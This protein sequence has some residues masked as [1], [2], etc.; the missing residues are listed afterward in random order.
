MARPI[1]VLPLVGSTT[2]APRLSAPRRSA[3]SIMATAIRSLTLPPGFSDSILARTAAPSLL[4]SRLSFTSGV[5]PTTSSTEAAIFGRPV[6]AGLRWV[7]AP[8]PIGNA[9]SP[10]KK[11]S[12]VIHGFRESPTL[13]SL[14]PEILE[15]GAVDDRIYGLRNRAPQRHEIARGISRHATAGPSGAAHSRRPLHGAQDSAHRDLRGRLGQPIT[16][17]RAAPRVEKPHSLEAQEHLF[18]V[19]LGNALALR[20]VLDGLEGVGIAKGQVEHGLDGVLALGGYLHGRRRSSTRAA[21]LAKYV[22]MMSASARRMQV[23]ASIMAASSSSQPSWPAARIIAYSPETEYAATGSPNSALTRESTSR[24]GR[25]G[26][27]IT[28]SAPSATSR[29][30]SRMASMALAGSI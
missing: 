16:A 27:A 28:M 8:N 9:S 23:S 18:E 1:P 5:P 19:T 11:G 24:Y 13:E 25:A 12:D 7:M 30:T 10:P 4:G 26:L 20:D 22:M 3:S 2:V 17:G 14:T 29:A 15:R 6:A 21:S